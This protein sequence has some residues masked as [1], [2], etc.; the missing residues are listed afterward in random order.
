MIA[1]CLDRVAGGRNFDLRIAE[2]QR[3]HPR[4]RR[5]LAAVVA[6]LCAELVVGTSAIV[7]VVILTLGGEPVAWAVW[8]RGLVVLG[9]TVT[10]FYFVWRAG[11]G[12]YWAY[13]RLRLFSVIFPIVTLSIAIIPGF[14]PFWMIA[15]QVVFSVLL[16][17]VAG[18]LQ[19]AHM[20]EVFAKPARRELNQA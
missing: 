19:T 7:V 14:F 15:Q 6:I 11:A 13:S 18:V 2:E 12:Y 17:G 3:I 16:M 9:I 5:M 4:T 10:L 8:F 20:R 1:E